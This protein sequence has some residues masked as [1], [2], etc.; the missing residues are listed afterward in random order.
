MYKYIKCMQQKKNRTMCRVGKFLKLD[1]LHSTF[2]R[3]GA[4]GR[5]KTYVR[6]IRNGPALRIIRLITRHM[7]DV[8]VFRAKVTVQKKARERKGERVCVYVCVCV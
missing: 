3:L 8:R 5:A 6:K 1:G 2:A 4:R 7:Y